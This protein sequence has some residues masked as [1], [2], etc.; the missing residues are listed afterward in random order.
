MA[1]SAAHATTVLSVAEKPSVAKEI[2]GVLGGGRATRVGGPEPRCPIWAFDCVMTGYGLV[3]MR[4]TSVLGHLHELE[5]LP[6]Y[7]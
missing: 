3:N 5:F 1:A 7:K 6:R 4:V 2:A